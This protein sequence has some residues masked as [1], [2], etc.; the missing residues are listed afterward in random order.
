MRK[1]IIAAGFMFLASVA[2]AQQLST[3]EIHALDDVRSQGNSPRRA[4][5]VLRRM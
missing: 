4:Q 5:S 3:Y 2:D 1:V